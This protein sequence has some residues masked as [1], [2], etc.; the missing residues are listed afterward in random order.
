VKG[1]ARNL[2]DGIAGPLAADQREYVEIIRDQAERLIAEAQKIIEAAR[3]SQEPVRL[4][5]RAVD[6]ASNAADA[7]RKLAPVAEERS[8][9]LRIE[10]E[11]PASIEGD[12]EKLRTVIENLLSNALKFTDAG[13]LVDVRI[14]PAG[15]GV[16]V[17]VKD[18]GLGIEPADLS[19]I[20]ERF[21]RARSDR[22]GSGVGL[23]LSRELVRL[24][25]GDIEVTS[26]PGAGSEFVVSLPGPA[27]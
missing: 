20:F 17:A 7:V 3:G 14:R 27:A 9:A 4:D 8:I 26:T 10:S 15:G 13:G 25:G 6:V 21:T 12:P 22:E 5:R 11:S 18:T 23:A 19:R 24:H 16:K 2:L 1:A